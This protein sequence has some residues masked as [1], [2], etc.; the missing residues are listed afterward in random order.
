MMHESDPTDDFCDNAQLAIDVVMAKSRDMA[1]SVTPKGHGIE[2]VLVVQ[3]KKCPGGVGPYLEYWVEH[4]HQL[5]GQ[6]D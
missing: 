5:G 4:S 3:M 1:L 6:K 2:H